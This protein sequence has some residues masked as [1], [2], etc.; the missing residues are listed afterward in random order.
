MIA[1]PLAAFCI[2]LILLCVA[3]VR[4]RGT[5]RNHADLAARRDMVRLLGL[6]AVGLGLSIVRALVLPTLIAVIL[7]S[8]ALVPV[9][10]ATIWLMMR[11]IGDYRRQRAR[12]PDPAL[13]DIETLQSRISPPS[14]GTNHDDHR[15]NSGL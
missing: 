11:L 3:A 4:L 5:P 15:R 7:F 13:P 14:N 6:L 12:L 8:V 9:G 1:V 2:V 10:I